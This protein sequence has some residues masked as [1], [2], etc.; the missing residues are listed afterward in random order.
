MK[1]DEMKLRGVW[2]VLGIC[3]MT[4]V[5]SVNSVGA[6]SSM[7]VGTLDS[8]GIKDL[9]KE[10]DKTIIVG[11]AAWCFPC[12]QELPTLIKLYTKYKD[13]GLKVIGISVDVNGPEAIQPT[14]DQE[15]VPFPVYWGGELAIKELKMVRLPLL[16]F[17][18]SGKVTEELVGI[19][20]E[21]VLEER[22]QA[23]LKP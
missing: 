5:V 22:I 17:F 11:M 3:M 18:K 12:R 20:E 6:G 9:I 1:G 4:L 8:A 14:V 23:L 19:Q 15:R 10:A 13:K 2:V 21:E 16:L 7:K